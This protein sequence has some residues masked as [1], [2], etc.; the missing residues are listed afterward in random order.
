MASTSSWFSFPVSGFGFDGFGNHVDHRTQLFLISDV[1][2]Q[3]VQAF[4][5]Q[6]DVAEENQLLLCGLEAA[7]SFPFVIG[8]PDA[9]QLGAVVV[10]SGQLQSAMLSKVVGRL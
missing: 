2:R 1:S 7:N 4:L 10:H 8:L 3:S 5:G 9:K 6:V